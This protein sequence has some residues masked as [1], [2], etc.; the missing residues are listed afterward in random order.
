MQADAATLHVILQH[1]VDCMRGLY[2]LDATVSNRDV[3]ICVRDAYKEAVAPEETYPGMGHLLQSFRMIDRLY[4]GA[5]I[6]AHY[7]PDY[8]AVAYTNLQ[9]RAAEA[10][11]RG[12]HLR[13]VESV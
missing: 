11:K 12:N 8:E 5:L 3:Y 13:I 6:A 9:R 1:I 7:P 2:G 4:S 10:A